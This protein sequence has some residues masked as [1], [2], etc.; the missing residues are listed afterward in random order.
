M[1]CRAYHLVSGVVFALVALMHLVRAVQRLPVVAGSWAIPLAAS[2]AGVVVA[3]L[4]S[5]WAFR[6]RG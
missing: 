3:G 6:S 4:L 2:W 1:S 5:L